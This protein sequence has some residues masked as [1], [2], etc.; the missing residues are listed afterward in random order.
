MLNDTFDS[1]KADLREDPFNFVVDSL[2][3]LKSQ[4][5]LYNSELPTQEP[6]LLEQVPSEL[7]TQITQEW[8]SKQLTNLSQK[9]L[10]ALRVY[11]NEDEY[12]AQVLSAE[13]LP[14]FFFT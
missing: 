10:D 8:Q 5:A 11:N 6:A 3:F 13:T 1:M 9:N 7:E 14:V 4:L 12:H 2:T